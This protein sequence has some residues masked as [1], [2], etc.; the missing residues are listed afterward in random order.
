MWMDNWEIT[1]HLC[2]T[3]SHLVPARMS[4]IAKHVAKTAR[5]TSLRL[6]CLITTRQSRLA[7]AIKPSLEKHLS[8]VLF[9]SSLLVYAVK[10]Y[11]YI[12]RR[13]I[14]KGGLF[15]RLWVGRKTSNLFGVPVPQDCEQPWH[16]HHRLYE[17]MCPHRILLRHKCEH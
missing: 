13:Y 7:C 12:K 14:E 5:T 8:L 10:N 9:Q 11:L 3:L 1:M 6:R 2:L 17:E 16:Q 15:F 4:L